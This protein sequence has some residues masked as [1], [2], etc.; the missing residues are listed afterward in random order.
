MEGRYR[1]TLAHEGGWLVQGVTPPKKGIDCNAIIDYTL[2]NDW[3][4]DRHHG[5]HHD[6]QP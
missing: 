1:F 2:S 5:E 4:G 3:N 6:S